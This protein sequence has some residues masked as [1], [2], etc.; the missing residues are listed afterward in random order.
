MTSE[1]QVA[2]YLCGTCHNVVDKDAV[3][4]A[5]CQTKRPRKGWDVDR[6]LG[7]K[8]FGNIHFTKR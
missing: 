6:R 3:S 1:A 5:S 8:L 2:P 7:Q 4:C